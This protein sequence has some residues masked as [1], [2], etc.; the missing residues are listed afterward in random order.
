M[1]MQVPLAQIFQAYKTVLPQHGIKAAED[2]LYYRLLISLSLRPE[3]SWWA[4]LDAEGRG[5]EGCNQAALPGLDIDSGYSQSP[6]PQLSAKLLA[7]R[8]RAEVCNQAALPCLEIN[9]ENSQGPALQQSAKLLAER[10]RADGCN[11]AAVCC[12]ERSQN[13]RPIAL[14]QPTESVR[15]PDGEGRRAEGCNGAALPRLE[16]GPTKCD[17]PATRHHDCSA[18]QQQHPAESSCGHCTEW[19][20]SARSSPSRPQA[21][22]PAPPLTSTSPK[23]PQWPGEVEQP[24]P[25]YRQQPMPDQRLIAGPSACEDAGHSRSRSAERP[26][27]HSSQH[28]LWCEAADKEA[29][30]NAPAGQVYFCHDQC[31]R[32]PKHGQEYDRAKPGTEHWQAIADEFLESNRVPLTQK[33]SRFNSAAIRK[34]CGVQRPVLSGP[35]VSNAA[36]RQVSRHAGLQRSLSGSLGEFGAQPLKHDSQ[37]VQSY[38]REVTH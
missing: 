15:Q 13:H 16:C 20:I 4:K 12:L 10:Q 24:E 22:L 36:G 35:L 21:F 27:F 38:A 18:S 7:E 26:P 6:A 30:R 32:Q 29:P 2:T 3:S 23:G 17:S 14:Q 34:G 5:A 28:G 19:R 33:A 8:R 31:K 9:S 1:P 37:S 25:H 11:G